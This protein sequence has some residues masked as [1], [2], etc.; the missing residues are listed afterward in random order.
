[1][2]LPLSARTPAALAQTAAN[3][4][5]WLS[6][7]PEAGLADVCLT[8]GTARAH[9][10]HRAAAV[11]NSL[12]SARDLLDALADDRPA[13]GLV[14]GDCADAP[15]TA[16]LFPGQGSQYVGMA[17]ELFDNEP[18]FAETM[19]QCAEAV[20]DVLDQPLLDVI[21]DADSRPDGSE[22]LQQT[23]HA[24]PAIFAVEMGL[25]RLWQ[26]WGF[27]PDVVL[28]HSVGQYAAACVARRVPG[29]TGAAMVVRRAAFLAAGGFSTDYIVGDFE[30]SDLCLALR[31]AGHEIGYEP[32]A[33][34]FH[35]E[36]QSIGTHAGHARTLA[37][38]YNRLL[39]HRRWDA[40]IAAL[41]ARFP[42]AA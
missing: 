39:Q 30:D 42:D 4:R 7:H 37:G 10:E 2:V 35:F 24:Q 33:E 3:Y 36:R 9:F 31:A 38:A 28:G 34:L 19:T 27:E 40:A 13:P 18:V 26:S 29:V 6:E 21:F 14:R 23:R 25:A 41:M 11:V 20:A 15:K 32:A 16:W 12:E 1:M 22:T 5:D 8:A 17:R